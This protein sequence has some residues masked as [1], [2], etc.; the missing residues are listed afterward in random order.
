MSLLTLDEARRAVVTSG[1]RLLR[2]C[3]T[4]DQFTVAV[5]LWGAGG[6][7]GL[8]AR[9]RALAD[10]HRRVLDDVIALGYGAEAA[11]ELAGIA[12]AAGFDPDRIDPA[13]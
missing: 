10:R 13:A 2:R 6:L 4:G 11:D 1:R 9:D 3:D 7:E 8:S 5:M 12:S